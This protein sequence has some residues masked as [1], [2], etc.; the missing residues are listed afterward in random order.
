MAEDGYHRSHSK[1]VT[2]T[3]FDFITEYRIQSSNV[4]R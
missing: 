3:R 1:F 2:V 4:K